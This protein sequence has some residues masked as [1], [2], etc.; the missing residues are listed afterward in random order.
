LVL[1]NTRK[2][3]LL[4]ATSADPADSP[5]QQINAK[6]IASDTYESTM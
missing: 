2:E 6:M 1:S 5:P 3:D 4:Q